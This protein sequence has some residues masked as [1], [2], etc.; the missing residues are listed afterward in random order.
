MLM[1]PMAATRNIPR[2][3]AHNTSSIKES[4]TNQDDKS[5][6]GRAAAQDNS[7]MSRSRSKYSNHGQTP[8]NGI[9]NKSMT[10]T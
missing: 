7:S 6:R 2:P 9:H 3:D 5:Q 1:S 4:T 8:T 10:N